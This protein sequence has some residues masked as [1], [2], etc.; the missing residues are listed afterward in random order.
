MLKAQLLGDAFKMASGA[1]RTAAAVREHL[2]GG[3]PG[4]VAPE[5]TREEFEAVAAMAAKARDVQEELLQRIATLE[6]K[7][8]ER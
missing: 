5:I 4:T 7:L 6:A 1:A 2:Q 3:R 8:S